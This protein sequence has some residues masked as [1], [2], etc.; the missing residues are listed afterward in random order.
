VGLLL[1]GALM[2][3]TQLYVLVASVSIPPVRSL[4]AWIYGASALAT[5]VLLL[6]R[7][8]L[9]QRSFLV[10]C[11]ALTAYVAIAPEL[12]HLIMIPSL[13]LIAGL[14]LF[15]YRFMAR[16]PGSDRPADRV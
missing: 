16:R 6:R 10:F 8:V 12:H 1:L 11:G 2:L 7:S 13:V 9:A 5:G 15:A 3:A 14:L 4:L